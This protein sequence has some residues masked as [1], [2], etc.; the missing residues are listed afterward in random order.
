[1]NKKASLLSVLNYYQKFVRE[2]PVCLIDSALTF[3]LLFVIMFKILQR[4]FDI[5]ITIQPKKKNGTL[6]NLKLLEN[7]AKQKDK[8][9]VEDIL[10]YYR[11]LKQ[12]NN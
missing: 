6:E 11:D 10:K 8:N 12:E 3:T 9:D 2:N 5:E 7:L 1:M 4:F